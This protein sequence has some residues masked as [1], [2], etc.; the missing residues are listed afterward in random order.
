[1]KVFDS[2]IHKYHCE[3]L[4]KKLLSKMFGKKQLCEND[5]SCYRTFSITCSW[6]VLF[7]SAEHLIVQ[8]HTGLSYLRF[9]SNLKTQKIR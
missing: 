8:D 1:M 6:V 5:C 7:S 2:V 9:H 3:M 4:L